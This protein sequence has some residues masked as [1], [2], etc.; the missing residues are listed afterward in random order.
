MESQYYHE[1]SMSEERDNIKWWTN[2][3]NSLIWQPTPNKFI[4][5]GG[6]GGIVSL[7]GLRPMTEADHKFHD[8]K[9]RARRESF[10][11][12]SYDA[13]VGCNNGTKANDNHIHNGK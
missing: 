6:C 9:E 13:L 4:R 2:E 3:D 11:G 8:D 5:I 1:L 12:K 10:G 7:V